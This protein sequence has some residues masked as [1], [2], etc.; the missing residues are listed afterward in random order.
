MRNTA[1]LFVLGLGSLCAM[2]TPVLVEAYPTASDAAY[3][4]AKIAPHNSD[5]T[6]CVS[7]LQSGGD[8]VPECYGPCQPQAIVR[9]NNSK[10]SAWCQFQYGWVYRDEVWQR[11]THE[12]RCAN[13]SDFECVDTQHT[14]VCTTPIGWSNCPADTCHQ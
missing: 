1:S 8:T 7:P 9:S 6:P 3:V 2:V 12:E 13:G 11:A 14:S 10:Y 5:V 4:L